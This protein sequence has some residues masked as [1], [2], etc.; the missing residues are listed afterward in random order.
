MEDEGDDV[1]SEQIHKRKM[2]AQQKRTEA[3][4][5]EEQLK[6]TLRMVLDEPAYARIMNVKMANQQMFTAAVQ[7]LLRAFQRFQRKITEEELLAVLR[8]LKE[9]S[10]KNTRITFERK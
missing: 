4:K 2:L 3:K 10:E 7:Y 6:S 9:R 8:T 5:A 1:R